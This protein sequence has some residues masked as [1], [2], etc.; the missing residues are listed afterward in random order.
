MAQALPDANTDYCAWASSGIFVTLGRSLGVPSMG[1]EGLV[2]ALMKLTATRGPSLTRSHWLN[3]C[4]RA[5]MFP[6]PATH[7]YLYEEKMPF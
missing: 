4:M 5:H 3:T 2:A 6:P 1:K 7:M